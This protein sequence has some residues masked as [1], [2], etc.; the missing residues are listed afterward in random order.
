MDSTRMPTD[1]AYS[2]EHQ[3]RGE[4]QQMQHDFVLLEAL[5]MPPLD[6]ERLAFPLPSSR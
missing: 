4:K 5:Q 6:G 2:L 3:S 1:G